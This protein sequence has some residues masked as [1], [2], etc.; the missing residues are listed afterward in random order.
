MSIEL[1]KSSNK[2]W[3]SRNRVLKQGA[4]R[5]MRF[6]NNNPDVNTQSNFMLGWSRI[7]LLTVQNKKF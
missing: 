3:S 2:L 4:I 6:A 5:L 7:C 1:S